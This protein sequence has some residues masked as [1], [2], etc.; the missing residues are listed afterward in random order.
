MRLA[1]IPAIVLAITLPIVPAL[2]QGPWQPPASGTTTRTVTVLTK[3]PQ[4]A[5]FRIPGGILS[6]VIWGDRIARVSL[7]KDGRTCEFSDLAIIGTPARVAWTMAAEP[8]RFVIAT[9]AM[10]LTVNADTGSVAL[11]DAKGAP[12]VS[13]TDP[14][15]RLLGDTAHP[16]G[17]IQ[18]RFQLY[19]AQ[20]IHGLGQHQTGRLDY[21]GTT[22]RL[23]Q[24]NTDVGIPVLVSS[25]G[26][27]IFWNNPAVTDVDVSI[28]QATDRIVFR[29]QAGSGIDYFLFAGPDVDAVIGSYRQLTGQAPMM[30]RWT[31]G[32]WQSKER[33]GSQAE[34]LG[35]A[36]KYRDL[37]IP[38]DAVV[39]D[40]QYWKPG[41]WGGH[42]LDP[43]RY[44]D[45]KAM[46]DT[47]HRQ[48]VHSIVS[49]WPRFDAGLD[50]TMALDAIG[51]LYPKT[52]PNVYPAGTGR[53][54]DAFSPAARSLYWRQV[55][56]RLGALGFD[57]YWLD[58]SEAE[59]GGHWGEMRDVTTAR[60]SGAIVYNAY[61]LL[62]TSAVHD[63][64]A[65][66]YPAKRPILLTRS[67]WAGQQRNAAITWSGDVSGRWDVFRAQ[68]PAGVKF[69]MTGIPYW[70]ADIGG[71]F[72]GDP[73]DA[74][75]Q[76]LFTRWLQFA[77][78]NPMFRIHGTGAGKELYSFPQAAR[79]PLLD[80]V[81]L[82]YRLMPFLY[83]Q[84]W[85]VTAGNASFL[86]PVDMLF[87]GD[88]H[89]RDLPSQ[90]MFG[91]SIMVSPVVEENAVTR[92]V[93]LPA[94]S[95]WYDF[96]TGKREAGGS[97]IVAA[98][99]L[100][101]MPLHI[102]TGTILPLGAPVQFAAASVDQP[103]ELRVYR[104]A[105]GHFTLYDDAGDG[106]AWR[107]GA[108]ATIALTLDDTAGVLVIGKR[109]G[110]YP[111]MR[112]DRIFRVVTVSE[113]AG[114]GL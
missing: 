7:C 6:V 114:T 104:G 15:R 78:F 98:A 76:Q 30:A 107:R 53:W 18:Q 45:G 26:F 2:A 12:L 25:A 19:G 74:G 37:G 11:L 58:G 34:L 49:I 80:A 113:R 5:T 91:R 102:K 79:A 16:D 41:E 38:L 77:V 112:R 63:G 39:Q 20:A 65:R 17:Q 66:D 8:D 67:A 111:G 24:A 14:D 10:R 52:Y 95:D 48:N 36:A 47:L 103:I 27:G 88:P 72:G 105:D 97:T 43:T 99:P 83:A 110:R 93:Y 56:D 3:T 50:T 1:A 4:G 62:H 73:K 90:F 55:S 86:Y 70:S 85:Q 57:G 64:M 96:W 61:P 81:K 87:P 9:P 40:W 92:Q 13:E 84:A 21:T 82:R 59:L 44:P 75:Y 33:Y 109:Q 68:V 108:Q 94:G 71:F 28:P 60:G 89:A 51:G 69:S 100:A 42:R 29:S 54:Y 23:Q 101:R 46:L 22:V 35:V 106:P 31:F 32:L